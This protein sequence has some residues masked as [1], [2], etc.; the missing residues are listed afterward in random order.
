MSHKTIETRT[1][2]SVFWAIRF[3][4]GEEGETH[5]ILIRNCEKDKLRDRNEDKVMANRRITA[6]LLDKN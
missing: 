6:V 1:E 5:P 2:K 3:G 4:R